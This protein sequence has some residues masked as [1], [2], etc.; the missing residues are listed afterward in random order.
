MP[1][2]EPGAGGHLSYMP[3][4]PDG[5]APGP[6]TGP[7]T[8]PGPAS[9]APAVLQRIPGREDRF[10]RW[11]ETYDESALQRVLHHPLH[12]TVLRLAR[13]KRPPRWILDVG[14]GTGH[15][16]DLTAAVYPRAGRV[17]IDPSA[18]MLACGASSGTVRLA[19]AE[20]ESLPFHDGQ[21][22]LV[23]S[24]MS[25]LRWAD[26]PAG[27]AELGRVCA[28]RGQ[29][30]IADAF[31]APP[32]TRAWCRNRL[33]RRLQTLFEDAGLELRKAYTAPS[34]LTAVTVLVVRKQASCPST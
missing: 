23:F 28:P 14:C 2:H 24:T 15:L 18:A 20:A 11:A 7:S 22:D 3:S 4:H 34:A 29:V 1:G 33:D 8:D 9:P 19:R 21:F 27:I 12:H 30:I 6:S 32:V 17:G 13:S 10:D 31:Q 5:A 25:L 26:P 16:L